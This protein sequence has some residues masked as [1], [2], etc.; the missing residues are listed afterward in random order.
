MPTSVRLR[1]EDVAIFGELTNGDFIVFVGR[2]SSRAVVQKK[3]CGGIDFAISDAPD[4]LKACT[5]RVSFSNF[6]GPIMCEFE[7]GMLLYEG[8][9][10]ALKTLKLTRWQSFPLPVLHF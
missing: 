2:P 6:V 9:Q 3:R 7:E 5:P 10:H 8:I 4:R 1:L